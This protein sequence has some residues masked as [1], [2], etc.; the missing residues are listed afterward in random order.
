MT[1]WIGRSLSFGIFSLLLPMKTPNSIDPCIDR[2]TRLTQSLV[3]IPSQGGVNSSLPICQALLE[4]LEEAGLKPEFLYHGET[5]SSSSSLPVGVIAEIKGD[6]P[7]P[8]YVLDAVVDTAPVG[9]PSLWSRAPFSGEIIQDRL[10]GRGSA[11][12]KVAAAIFVEVGRQLREERNKIKG[13]TVLFFD[14][15]EHTG[16]FEGVQALLERYPP[17]NLE[18]VLIGYPGNDALNIGSRGFERS[19]VE[20]TIKPQCAATS[21]VAV[22]L[23]KAIR[24]LQQSLERN[25]IDEIDPDFGLPPK[26]TLTALETISKRPF[27]GTSSKEETYARFKICVGGTAFHSGSSRNRGVNA[28]A[29]AAELMLQMGSL[30]TFGDDIQVL[31]LKTANNG[32]SIVPDLL[33]LVV[34]IPIGNDGPTSTL[35]SIQKDLETLVEAIQKQYPS[36]GISFVQLLEDN[37][38]GNQKYPPE[39]VSSLAISVDTRTVPSFEIEQSRATLVQTSTQMESQANGI[40][41]VHVHNQEAWP[42][43]CLDQN[44]SL[45]QAMESAIAV[46]QGEASIPSKVSGPSNVGNLLAKFG[47][48]ATTGY[49]VAFEGIHA[50]NES[51]DLTTIHSTLAVYLQ[52]MQRLMKVQER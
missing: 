52:A 39:V 50:T 7:G 13:S 18:G 33:E 51:I 24:T 45:R 5:S 30:S 38:E 21:N 19:S 34:A 36:K 11:D 46:E 2:I 42:A 48:P 41:S 26:R 15:A 12:S 6:L 9:D 31:D 37:K 44:H 32:F 14:A 28:I 20:V 49:G 1:L 35:D 16:K 4:P 22:M 27:T 3:R 43:F 17:S 8:T 25:A 47:V 40:L 23:G 29:K 10:Y